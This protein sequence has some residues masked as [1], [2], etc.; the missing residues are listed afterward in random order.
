MALGKLLAAHYCQLALQLCRNAYILRGQRR[1]H[2][3]AEVCSFVST[4]CLE[5]EDDACK[6]EAE[7]CASSA[8]QFMDG[9]YSEGEKM[10]VEARK[11]CPMNYVFRGS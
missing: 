7:L 3:A 2:E 9:N 11:S 10:C 6:R 5:N 1:Y 4:L 8:R